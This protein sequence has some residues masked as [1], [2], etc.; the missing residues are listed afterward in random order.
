MQKIDSYEAKSK[1]SQILR[2]VS[3]GEEF[4]ITNHGKPIAKLVPANDRTG[5]DVAEVIQDLQAFQTRS[6]CRAVDL[7]D[8]QAA[9][10]DGRR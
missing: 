10:K 3:D 6:D 2:A 9:K 1:F 8:V 4:L 5:R 7:D